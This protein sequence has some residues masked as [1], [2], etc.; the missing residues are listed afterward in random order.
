MGT[1]HIEGEPG[2]VA[3]KVLVPGDPLRAKFIAENFLDKPR[4]YSNIR[5]MCGFTGH[6][7]GQKISVQGSGMGIP[8]MLIYATE[9]IDYFGAQRLLRLGT[10]GAI[11][12][13]IQL[14]DIILPMV[15]YTDTPFFQQDFQVAGYAPNADFNFMSNAHSILQAQ[16][17]HSFHTGP[18]V[19]SSLFYDES[20]SWR[21]WAKLGALAVEM[22][23]SA[24]YH[25]ARQKGREALALLSVSDQLTKK[26]HS[27]SRYL[28]QTYE[29][30][31]KLALDLLVAA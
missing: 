26:E 13:N 11:Q 1:T 30:M 20:E 3:E 6:Y 22:E 7:K 31:I 18:I 19:T 9:L 25:V 12:P 10:C 2:E 5:N 29:D 14:G 15:A 21:S 8:S 16:S 17:Q 28:Y 4:Q 23:T 27:S 24:L